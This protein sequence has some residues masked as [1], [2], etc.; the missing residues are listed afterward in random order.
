[1]S[2]LQADGH[3]L[4]FRCKVIQ[5]SNVMSPCSPVHFIHPIGRVARGLPPHAAPAARAAQN[6]EGRFYVGMTT[7]LE[8][9]IIDHNN[10]ISKWTN[11]RGPWKLVWS[12]ACASISEARKLENK[13]KRQGRGSG[14]YRMIGSFDLI[15]ISKLIGNLKSV[16]RVC[17]LVGASTMRPAFKSWAS[18]K[19]GPINCK[20][21]TGK[22]S[23]LTGTGTARAGFPA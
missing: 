4:F 23:W 14:F 11:Y 2:P 22:C 7:G 19:R 16:Y 15:L 13:L 18:L 3:R 21:V 12:Q 1:M 6:A 9:R 5:S 20:L 17:V 8:Q 10:G